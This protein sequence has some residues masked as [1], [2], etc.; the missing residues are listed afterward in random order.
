MNILFI[1]H[2]KYPHVG[3]VEKHVEKIKSDLIEKGHQVK[4]VSE[5]DIKFPHIKFIG[6]LCIWFWFFKNRD[7]IKNADIIHIHDVFI[8]YLPFRF[9]YPS[10]KV[11]TTIHGGQSIWPIPFYNKLLVK[12]ASKLSNGTIAVGDFIRKYFNIISDYV[13]YGGVDEENISNKKEKIIIFLGRL[14]KDTGVYEFIQKIKKY[15]AYKIYFIG[16]GSLRGV[17]NKYGRVTGFINPQDYLKKASICFA[18]GYLSALEAL[19]YGCTLWVGAKTPIKKYYWK[20]FPYKKGSMLPSWKDVV[21]V[22]ESL[23]M[24]NC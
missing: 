14:E 7:L 22:Y 23:Y 24:Y 21:K 17:C 4:V 2:F 19:K 12:I 6:L 16:D 18:G 9:I 1:S 10:K 13:I 11:F 15:K 5:Q 20:T 3:G 8:W